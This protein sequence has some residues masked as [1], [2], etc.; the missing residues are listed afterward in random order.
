MN[1]IGE[2]TQHWPGPDKPGQLNWGEERVAWWLVSGSST[3]FN[4]LRV[5]R[6]LI[7]TFTLGRRAGATWGERGGST[8]FSN[9]Y[10]DVDHLSK[11]NKLSNPIVEGRCRE[12]RV[13]TKYVVLRHGLWA[14]TDQQQMY[15]NW[16]LRVMRKLFYTALRN[17]RKQDVKRH[18]PMNNG[19]EVYTY[20]YSISYFGLFHEQRQGWAEPN[21]SSLAKYV[22][23]IDSLV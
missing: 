4:A 1:M 15:S 17:S 19:T 3:K 14:S 18:L 20:V 10:F 11:L 2:R 8:C 21:E 9:A 22:A 6:A 7:Y 5:Q 23:H 16:N 13:Y 12:P